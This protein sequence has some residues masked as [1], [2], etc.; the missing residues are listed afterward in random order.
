MTRERL[1]RLL[2]AATISLL[3][4]YC[5]W[6]SILH[7]VLFRRSLPV[8]PGA[9]EVSE[10]YGYYGADTGLQTLCFWTSDSLREVQAYYETFTPAFVQRDYW[11]TFE[12]AEHYRTVFNPNGGPLPV[13]TAEFADERINPSQDRFCYYRIA[14]QC[15]EIELIDFGQSEPVILRPP[16]GPMNMLKT[17]SPLPPELRGGTLIIYIYYVNKL[18]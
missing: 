10:A 11:F 2:I 15:V 13:V 3:L 5:V 17:P 4:F 16:D 6:F 8:Y 18:S 12:K 7:N 9:Q 1:R 14:Y